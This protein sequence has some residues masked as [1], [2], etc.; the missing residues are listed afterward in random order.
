M[1]KHFFLGEIIADAWA[2]AKK[3]IWIIMGFTGIQFIVI[4]GTFLLT[5]VFGQ[6]GQHYQDKTG[7]RVVESSALRRLS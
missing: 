6:K 3:N 5:G 2:L 7:T 1:D 4:L